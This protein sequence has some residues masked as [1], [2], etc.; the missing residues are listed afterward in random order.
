M[1]SIKSSIIIPTYNKIHRL[2]VVLESFNMQNAAHS[3]FEVVLVDDGSSDDTKLMIDGMH[4]NYNFRY[5][6]QENQGRSAARNKGIEEAK[7][8][9]LIFCDDDTIP[10]ESFV[11]NHISNHQSNKELL[12]H[13]AIFDLLPLKFFK[14]PVNGVFFEVYELDKENYKSLAK[15]VLPSDLRSFSNYLEKNRRMSGFEKLIKRLF[16]ENRNSLKWMACTGGNF[17]VKKTQL[18]KSGV[19]NEQFGKKWGCED[20]ELGYRLYKAGTQ[21]EYCQEAINYHITHVRG[22]YEEDISNSVSLFKR[23]HPDSSEIDLEN[24]LLGN[25]RSLV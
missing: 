14:D 17:S 19:F 20:L 1:N 3:D 6:F 18:R 21:F 5:F 25:Y 8:E 11:E 10:S 15:N 12:V 24:L 16:D 22:N 13:G 2:K 7:G 9:I 4:F 23:I